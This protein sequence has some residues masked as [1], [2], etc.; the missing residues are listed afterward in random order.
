MYN[1]FGGWGMK[2]LGGLHLK[3]CKKNSLS[4]CFWVWGEGY[5]MQSM[6]EREKKNMHFENNNNERYGVNNKNRI[7]RCIF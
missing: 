7:K 6:K 1:F 2:V 3:E 5:N 4:F